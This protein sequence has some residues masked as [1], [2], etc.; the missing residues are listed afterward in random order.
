MATEPCGRNGLVA[1]NE[2]L[3]IGVHIACVVIRGRTR[4]NVWQ[5]D[6]HEDMRSTLVAMSTINELTLVSHARAARIVLMWGD[7]KAGS[8]GGSRLVIAVVL[9][10]K[11][12]Q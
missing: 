9:L 11:L 4:G 1:R 3:D 8:V 12:T 7:F 6:R 2:V 10:K 5:M